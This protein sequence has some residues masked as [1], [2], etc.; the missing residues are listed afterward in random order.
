M[1]ANQFHEYGGPEV[2]RYGDTPD[3]SPA[4]GE[5]VIRV[6]ACGLNHLDLDLRDG[7]SRIPLQLPF[8]PGLEIAG[9]I[10]DLGAGV[11]GYKVGERVMPTFYYSC[12]ECEY[13]LRKREN[14]CPQR[15]MFG[16]FRPGGY[17]EL[18]TAPARTLM[19]IPDSV[20]F[21]DAAATQVAFGTAFHMLIT[22][23]QVRPG[24]SVLIQA[25]GSGIG[26]AALQIAARTGLKIIATAGSD[27]K[28]RKAEAMGAQYTIN[29]KRENMLKAVMDYTDGKG[30]DVV[31]EH[32]GGEVFSDSVKALAMWGRLVTCGAHAGEAPTI[33][34]IELFRKEASVIGSYTCSLFELAQVLA[35]VELGKLKPVIH[36]ALPLAEAGQ[37]QQII[38][39]REQFG[40]VVLNP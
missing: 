39:K 21:D 36:K 32:V 27:E 38:A 25:A 29:Y 31:Y 33:D 37:A 7:V 17:A 10:A 15:S 20:S 5:V 9:E 11:A 35:L 8:I 24:E 18:V 23:A 2:M 22:R 4:A 12:G 1:K 3:P 26:S 30:V 13:C 28:L 14:L 6:R 40:K 19:R 16:V 34:V